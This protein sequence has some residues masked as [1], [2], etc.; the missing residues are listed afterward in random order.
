MAGSTLAVTFSE[1]RERVSHFLGMGRT[2]SALSAGGQADVD[3]AITSGLRRFYAERD[4]TFLRPTTTLNTVSGEYRY[5]LPLWIG[6][7]V[8]PLT[9]EPN[10]VG[11]PVEM[12]GEGEI[13][14][15][16]QR[17]DSS[18]IPRYGAVRWLDSDGA[19]QQASEL[20]LW[21]VPDGTYTLSF[22]AAVLAD[23]LVATLGEY[24][25]GGMQHGETLA[26]ACLA[27][28]ES[29]MQDSEGVH[30]VL[31]TKALE[32]SIRQDRKNAP[33]SLGFNSDPGAGRPLSTE[34]ISWV[35]YNGVLYP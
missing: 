5:T 7:I 10:V 19:T 8:G 16:R 13:R 21:P 17:D 1:L 30:E 20:L 4:W 22:Q 9:F 29:T 23:A 34:R 25:Y 24:P 11:R 32:R 6:S 3:E 35:R 2:Y 12:V 28:A 33:E 27:A 18:G 26:E 31:Y 14:D 15:L